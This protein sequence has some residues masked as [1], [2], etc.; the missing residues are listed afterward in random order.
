MG[1]KEALALSVGLFLEQSL[2]K[3]IK[4]ILNNLI[5]TNAETNEEYL[6]GE[7]LIPKNTSVVIRRV[8][9]LRCM[10]IVVT[11]VVDPDKLLAE[12]KLQDVEATKNS[13]S[14]GDSS[15]S[16]HTEEP[17]EWDEQWKYLSTP[18]VVPVQGAPPN[19][20]D[21]DSKIRALIDAPALDWQCY[22]DSFGAGRGSGR[23][24]DGRSNRRGYGRGGLLERITPPPGYICHRC[25][26][27]GHL[28]QH[29]STNGD[30][31]FDVKRTKPPTGIPKS[32]LMAT[33]DGSYALPSGLFTVLKPSE[34]AFE[35]EIEGMPTTLR[36]TI[37]RI[38]ESNNSSGANS[39]STFQP[40]DMESARWSQVCPPVTDEEMQ[41][42][43]VSGEVGKKRKKKCAD[44]QTRPHQD[45][46]AENYWMPMEPFGY[47]PY[48]HRMQPEFDRFGRP[49]DSEMPFTGYGLG[50]V[51]LTFGG[52]FYH[53]QFGAQVYTPFPSQRDLAELGKDFNHG[54]G[55]AISQEDVASAKSKINSTPPER[56]QNHI[57]QVPKVLR[58]S[59]KRK[60]N[61]DDDYYAKNP[62][63]HGEKERR[64][65]PRSKSASASR[66]SLI[67][68]AS[69]FG[70]A[71]LIGLYGYY[72]KLEDDKQRREAQ[73]WYNNHK[74]QSTQQYQN[75]KHHESKRF[76]P[77]NARMESTTKNQIN[78]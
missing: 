5:V 65:L 31:T 4:I 59:S 3:A 13:F 38:L 21:E 72:T 75:L 7:T 58:S 49:Y 35:K 70:T 6:D 24:M 25:N 67:R 64:H 30:P 43:Q 2:K 48:W 20:A 29:C 9:L 68:G 34:D 66:T 44:L 51:S 40:Q 23:G 17:D 45:F 47:N 26:V 19:K 56:H 32:M 74:A 60:V 10:P 50:P 63:Q 55:R 52:A 18:E 39:G 61:Y 73:A 62:H 42:K 12:N 16:I 1:R 41:Q 8:P 28:I 27:P 78:P 54:G 69:S 77:H 36:G 22:N 57:T 14:G 37:V 53:D 76:S 46:A 33:L 11:P 71:G 15:V